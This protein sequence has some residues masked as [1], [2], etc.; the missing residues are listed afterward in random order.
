MGL[1]WTRWRSRPKRWG[2]RADGNCRLLT[3]SLESRLVPSG[4]L[5]PGSYDPSTLLVRFRTD[6][7]GAAAIQVLPGAVLKPETDLVPG[8]DKVELPPGEGVADALARYRT[9]PLVLYAEPNYFVHAADVPNDTFFGDLWG[10][11]NTGQIVIGQQG[12]AGDDIHA[13][14]AW[15]RITGTTTVPVAN[16]DSGIDYTHPDLYD[17]IWIN[18]GEIPAA[19][20]RNLIDVDGDGLITFWDL[21][22]P[23]NQGPGKIIGRNP[24]QIDAQDIL[25]P[26]VL[27]GNGNDTGMGGWAYPGNTQDGD[28]A[29]PNDF[30]GWNFIA[31]NNQPLDDYSHGSHTAGILGAVGNNS[32]GVTGVLWKAQIASLKFL[33][34]HGT[35]TDADSILA[36]NYAVRHHLPISNNS[37][38]G[39][40]FSQAVLNALTAARNA[41]HVFVAAA[42]NNGENT[43]RNPFYPADYGVNNIVSVAATDNR[44]RLASFSDYGATSVHLAAPGVNVYS[45]VPGGLYSYKSGTSMSTPYV[46]GVVAMVEA[47]R[48]Q[49]SFFQVINQ[50]FATVDPVPLLAG[51]TLTGGR[52]DA[53]RTV[54]VGATHFGVTAP[55]QATAGTAIAATVRALDS[56]GATDA[57]YTGT[58]HFTATDG[59]AALPAN[60]TFT[61]AD[62]GVHTFMLTLRTAGS[63][64]VTVADT[65]LASIAGSTAVMVSPAA[66]SNFEVRLP[67]MSMAGTAFDGTIAVLDPYR[68]VVPTYRGTVRFG[69]DD[70]Q[71]TLPS[72]YT[73]TVADNGVHTFAGGVTLRTAGSHTVTA[74]DTGTGLNGNGSILVNPAAAGR[75]E[76]TAPTTATAG[77]AFSVTLAARDAFGNLATGY[78][79]TVGFSSSDPQATLPASYPFSAAD[80]GQHTFQGGVT[81][82]T[83]GSRGVTAGDTANGLM[84]SANVLVSPAAASRFDVS[85]PGGSAAGAAFDVTV[86]A[87]DPFAN[88]AVGYRG[89]VSLTSSDDRATLPG[90]YTFGPADA[91][92]HVFP[93]AVLV[94]AGGQSITAT[95]INVGAITGSAAVTVV[96]GPA[97]H[98]A[99]DTRTKISPGKLCDVTVIALDRYGNIDTGYTGTVTFATSDPDPRVVLPADYTFMAGDAGMV[100]FAKAS[101]LLT[102]GDQTITATD[103]VTGITGSAL[104]RVSHKIPLV[105]S[106]GRAST[107][108]AWPW[109][110]DRLSSRRRSAA[111]DE[112]LA[113][114]ADLSDVS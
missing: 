58:V 105:G 56:T 34:N 60:Y 88:V 48:P 36:I 59:Q 81:L 28:I 113:F 80:G 73:F 62:N 70:G 114:L 29:H 90:P 15:R 45:T 101:A 74:T 9:S 89:T 37:W 7:A 1:L 106:D 46:T 71:A 39:G 76:I 11:Q 57:S 109:P 21:Q 96:A 94:T 83:A 23:R 10:L 52:L 72:T 91:G 30:V 79:G 13:V 12:I 102:P 40:N 103:T 18:Q 44:D 111:E 66:A 54:A 104:V 20:R 16:I 95:D 99:V 82:R 22:D 107:V 5:K 84:I 64:T 24:G 55:A 50:V 38:G 4:I 43:D 65:S 31:D 2:R 25:A 27:D 69:S 53:A 68:N 100:V 19:R 14:D 51:K 17:N 42:G 97:D 92:I 67:A 8:L 75:L 32:L 85:A 61:A 110:G 47:L 77:S 87:R 93:A 33:D 108:L 26:M 98:F 86:T 3:E 41:G 6:A 78:R 35:G 112:A 63:Q 49:W